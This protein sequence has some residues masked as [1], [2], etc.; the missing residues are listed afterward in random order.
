MSPHVFHVVFVSHEFSDIFP[1]EAVRH[2]RP[3][4]GIRERKSLGEQ[5]HRSV[6]LVLYRPGEGLAI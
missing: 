4:G 3:G 5:K 6:L 1:E 2:S